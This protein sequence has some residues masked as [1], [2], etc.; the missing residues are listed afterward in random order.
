MIQEGSQGP[1]LCY[2]K[3]QGL[4]IDNY[5]DKDNNKQEDYSDKDNNNLIRSQHIKISTT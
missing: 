4:Y 2:K 1:C 3:V 5:S